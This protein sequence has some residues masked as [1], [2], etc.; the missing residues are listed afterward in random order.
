MLSL[1]PAASLGV[2]VNGFSPDFTM[3]SEPIQKPISAQ[4]FVEHGAVEINGNADFLS[5]ASSEGW[6]GTGSSSSPIIISGYRFYATLVQPVRI[7]NTDLHWIFENNI[8]TTDGVICGLWTD[9]TSAGIIRNNTFDTCHSG[10]V[11]YDTNNIL[12]ENNTVIGNTGN[13]IETLGLSDSIIRYNDFIALRNDG[14]ILDDATNVLVSDNSIDG[15][16]FDG[17]DIKRAEN[18]TIENNIIL[19]TRTGLRLGRYAKDILFKD[20]VVQNTSNNGVVCSGDDNQIK[21]N[22]I[23]NIG[24][25]GIAFE[26]SVDKYAENNSV[27]ANT[28]INCTEYGVELKDN[29]TG[30]I[31]RNNDFFGG[32]SACHICDHAENSIIESNF[33]DTWALPDTDEN[34]IVDSPYVILGSS[35][36]SDEKPKALPNNEIP[37]DYDY[38]PLTPAGN[39]GDLPLGT[40]ALV[41]GVAIAVCLI[42]VMLV[43]RRA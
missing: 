25:N 31:I 16:T 6:P 5:T 24:G 18:T 4:T 8:V 41:I 10:M 1:V 26:V 29:C 19:N 17:I 28:F 39:I 38:V 12:V 22:I 37:A 32:G 36:N 7:W 30:N 13:G 15:I 20:N 9:G 35:H 2:V 11:L 3:L 34:D 27:I 23:R 21:N 40:I 43:R 14:I 42:V 33:Y